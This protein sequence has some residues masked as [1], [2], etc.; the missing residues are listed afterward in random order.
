MM[1]VQTAREAFSPP[2]RTSSISKHE[3]F[4]VFYIF[5][6]HFCPPGSGPTKINADP[7]PDL[8][9]CCVGTKAFLEVEDQY[10][11]TVDSSR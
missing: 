4:S 7:D 3:F 2:K 6:G 11:R 8:Q 9:H 1:D 5:A 10:Q